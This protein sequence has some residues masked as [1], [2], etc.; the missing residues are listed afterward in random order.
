VSSVR[1]ETRQPDSE[2]HI[3]IVI[4]AVVRWGG[5]VVRW[6]SRGGQFK[7]WSKLSEVVRRWSN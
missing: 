2:G 1:G 4:Y 7:G 3:A 5:K 6:W